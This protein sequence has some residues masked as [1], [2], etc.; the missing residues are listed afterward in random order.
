[1]NLILITLAKGFGLILK[2]VS[3]LFEESALNT[4]QVILL[5]SKDK[6]INF[7]VWIGLIFNINDIVDIIYNP[8]LFRYFE[9]VFVTIAAFFVFLRIKPYAK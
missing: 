7:F 8:Y 9:I 2:S 3:A 5:L 6:W 4:L 1:M